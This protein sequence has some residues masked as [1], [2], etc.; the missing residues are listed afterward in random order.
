MEQSDAQD[1]TLLVQMAEGDETALDRL[2]ARHAAGLLRYLIGWGNDRAEAEEILQ[3]TFVAAWRAA[4]AFQGRSRVRTWLFAIA[5][6]QARDRRRRHGLAI[7]AGIEL[8]QLADP[9]TGPEAAALERAQVA[10][11][12]KAVAQL[13]QRQREVLAL[14][15]LNELSQAEIAQV[16]AIPIGTVKS[17][18]SSARHALKALLKSCREATE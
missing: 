4:S 16:L 18:L 15:F 7:E 14:L 12:T 1:A 5:Q 8:D 3:D 9:A 6:R 2:Y 17:R 13:S 10:E 11:L